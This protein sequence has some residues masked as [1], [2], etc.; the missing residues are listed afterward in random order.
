ME[1][2]KNIE[3]HNNNLYWS[4]KQ[5][6]NDKENSL[7]WS[8][9]YILELIIKNTLTYNKLTSAGEIHESLTLFLNESPQE[10]DDKYAI[11][12]IENICD[13]LCEN[14]GVLKKYEIN[15][16]KYYKLNYK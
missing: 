9:N 8:I 7:I 11:S 1:T 16:K 2:F 12:S 14:N 10:Q 3:L 5:K 13:A 4:Y 15:V 6:L